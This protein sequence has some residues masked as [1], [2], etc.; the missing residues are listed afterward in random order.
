MVAM[1]EAASA[2]GL[3]DYTWRLAYSLAPFLE[4]QGHWHD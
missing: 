2:G 3:H 4:R 1:V